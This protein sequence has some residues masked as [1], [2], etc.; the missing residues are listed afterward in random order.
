MIV[1]DLGEDLRAAAERSLQH[2]LDKLIAESR[3]AET[4]NG[5]FRVLRKTSQL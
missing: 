4:E 2:H 3:V 5:S 1:Q